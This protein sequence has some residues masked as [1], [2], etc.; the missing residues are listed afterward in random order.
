MGEPGP[1]LPAT[2]DD[3]AG[4]FG[5]RPCV[6][7][8]DGRVVTYRDLAAASRRAA[9]SLYARGVRTGD[10]VGLLLPSSPDHL[11]AYVGLARLGAVTVGI[12]RRLP[13]DDRQR[14]VDHL[15]PDLLVT[16]EELDP[17]ADVPTVHVRPGGEQ[18]LAGL[19]P[20]GERVPDLPADPDRPVALVLTSGTTG[21]PRAATFTDRQ[22]AAIRQLDVGDR[23]DGGGPMLA[24]TE[25]VHV[26]MVT[27]PVWYWATGATLHL[28]DRWR[29]ADA[30]RVIV[31]QRVPVLGAIS[32]QV[33]LMLRELD[34]GSGDDVDVSHVQALVVGGGPSPPALVR[35][36]RERFG[37]PYSVRYSSTES[38]GV[39]T[40][41]AFDA[42][43][44][45]ALHTVGRPRPG[46][47]L[48]VRRDDG[49]VAEV[50]E[51]GRVHLRSPA[52]MAG[53]WR[54]PDA[55]A[56]TLVDGWLRTDDLG[57]V[58]D[59][60]CLRL[61]GRLAD[62]YVR[63]GHNV[64]PDRVEAVLA[65]HPDLAEVAV[66]GVPDPVMGSVGVAVVVPAPGRPAPTLD[67]LRGFAAPR[68][69]RH[70]LP[71]RCVPVEALARTATDKVDRRALRAVVEAGRAGRD[72][73]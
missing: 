6:V 3:A 10:L 27:K 46:V 52:V 62:S 31:E 12:N 72:T 60:G 7:G 30:L 55:T 69:A 22:L 24:S 13:P 63:G 11:A 26:G 8:A 1:L 42:P 38:G 18:L 35:A 39:G 41:T 32:S 5:E 51:V 16:T 61:A 47:D 9:A 40:G 2:L 21:P 64:H 73:G 67:A 14:V 49:S 44:E 70:E 23:R 25:L 54:D 66:L 34:R 48:E 17:V 43:D 29:A 50:G 15:A 33:A 45:E 65:D 71:E 53:W 58:D 20:A 56:R 37:A 59:R 19:G 36:A 4:R 68:L 28:L 57:L